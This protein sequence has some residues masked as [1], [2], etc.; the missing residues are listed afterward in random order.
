LLVY[1]LRSYLAAGELAPPREGMVVKGF[2]PEGMCA[3]TEG[4][5]VKFQ[6]FP[7]F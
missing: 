4:I 2:S 5:L 6:I 1:L 7:G 3:R